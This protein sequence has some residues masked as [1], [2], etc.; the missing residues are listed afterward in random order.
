MRHISPLKEATTTV[1]TL[2]I[3]SPFRIYW[4][5]PLKRLRRDII[6]AYRKN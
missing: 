1:N 2:K 5:F 4:G 3:F 6:L